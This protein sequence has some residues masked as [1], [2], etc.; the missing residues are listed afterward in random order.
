MSDSKL[1]KLTTQEFNELWRRD[2]QR[3]ADKLEAIRKAVAEINAPIPDEL[4]EHVLRLFHTDALSVLRGHPGFVL[5]ERRE[6]FRASLSIMFLSLSDLDSA[7]V[8][9]EEQAT[10]EKAEIMQLQ[11]RKQLEIIEQRI[12]KELFATANAAASLV[13]HARRLNKRFEF[14]EFKDQVLKCF[15]DDGLHDL[16]IA[17]RVLLHHLH[18]VQAGWSLQ[19]DYVTGTRSA[20]FKISRSEIEGAIQKF[21]DRFGGNKGEPM[22]MFL[23]RCDDQI[24]ILSLFREY[25]S[26]V[27]CFYDWLE[28]QIEN[29]SPADLKD[30]DRCILEKRKYDTRMSWNALIGNWL[31]WERVP[32]IHEHLPD[33][34]STEQLEAVYKFPRNSKEQADFLIGLLDEDGAADEPTRER[35]YKLFER[36]A[37]Q[38]TEQ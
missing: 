8:E 2:Q 6:H 9:F 29:S 35:I 23:S 21:P 32:D 7:L 34:L 25:R 4:L 37:A 1:P 19:S 30:Y 36:L 5:S 16:I 28:D 11:N 31:N 24:N 10:T 3:K 33:Y 14:P 38:E 13:D 22:R 18:V 20:K 26:R 17:L 27:E 12:Q 15:K